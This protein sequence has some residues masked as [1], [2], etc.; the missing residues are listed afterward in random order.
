[1]M[2][3]C[4]SMIGLCEERAATLQRHSEDQITKITRAGCLHC[5]HTVYQI[6]T[7]K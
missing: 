3:T 4:I 5:L 2:L 7:Y 1:M 6:H